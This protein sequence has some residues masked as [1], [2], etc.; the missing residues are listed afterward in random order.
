MLE[1]MFRENHMSDATSGGILGKSVQRE[2]ADFGI[3]TL[4]PPSRS[5]LRG[6]P[7]EAWTNSSS[8]SLFFLRLRASPPPM[9]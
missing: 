5:Q 6:M 8:P 1:D 9:T 4:M 7:K 2:I 3:V